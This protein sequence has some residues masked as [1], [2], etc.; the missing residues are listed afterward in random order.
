M[1]LFKK[2]FNSSSSEA[3]QD[4]I[5]PW[6]NLTDLSKL[7]DIIESSNNKIQIIFK[8]STRCGISRMVI[9]QFENDYNL[10]KSEADLYYLDLL[11]HRDISNAIANTFSVYHESPQLLVI[12][13]GKVIAHD[14]HSAINN[15]D[16]TAFV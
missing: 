4:K 14:S 12:K 16:L 7:S 10:N 2:I 9:K 1:S 3:K 11:N 13:Q 15:M 6:I 8:H 5:L